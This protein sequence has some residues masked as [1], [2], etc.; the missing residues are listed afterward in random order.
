MSLESLITDAPKVVGRSIAGWSDHDRG[1][2]VFFGRNVSA[3]GIFWSLAL[4]FCLFFDDAYGADEKLQAAEHR[5]L[6][7]AANTE[8]AYLQRAN[9]QLIAPEVQQ[10]IQKLA[11]EISLAA[12]SERHFRVFILNESFLSSQSFGN[13][14]VFLTTSY[15]DMVED[16][17]E[18]AFALA[19][20]IAMQ[21]KDLRLKEMKQQLSDARRKNMW[22]FAFNTAIS[23]TIG[24]IYGTFALAPIEK[25]INRN[26][27]TPIL[28]GIKMVAPPKAPI[29]INRG[30]GGVILPSA[31][32]GL[33]PQG[34]SIEN[35]QN[36]ANAQSATGII[37]YFTD[38]VPNLIT[39]K[40]EKITSHMVSVAYEE[41][42][43]ERRKLKNDL[44]LTFMQMAGY[45]SA[46]AI[47]VIKKLDDFWA[48]V[49]S[50]N[51]PGKDA[52]KK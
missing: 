17:D 9:V 29:S 37:S 11:D 35:P 47:K 20:E 28:V 43:P 52:I 10:Q 4:L 6:I 21:V 2:I 3:R 19:R 13:G 25:A 12:G 18:L 39:S 34:V 8:S 1:F 15:L 45:N 26:T 48:N 36:V 42:D 30:A 46:S 50:T 32:V 7:A 23:A 22:N 27:A 40:L 49:N 38:Y 41:A 5:A 14:D 31:P 44:G 51:A 16:R 33:Q 24:G